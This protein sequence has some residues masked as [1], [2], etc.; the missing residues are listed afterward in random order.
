MNKIVYVGQYFSILEIPQQ[1]KKTNIYHIYVD[2]DT[3]VLLGEIKWY[4]HWR[5]YCFYA[6]NDIIWDSKCLTELINF[7]DKLNL[8]YKNNRKDNFINGG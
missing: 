5:K 6:R 3:D 1:N 2:E 8:E 4:N 7:L